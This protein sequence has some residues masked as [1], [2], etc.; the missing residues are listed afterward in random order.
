MKK[1]LL[2]W[3]SGVG[4]VIAGTALSSFAHAAAFFT[5]ATG[6]A[7]T[8]T[9]NTGAQISDPGTVEIIAVAVGI[10]LAFYVIAQLISFVPRYRGRVR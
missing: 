6:T 5:V 7:A 10:P 1:K 3:G 4:A 9:A 2:L 8:L